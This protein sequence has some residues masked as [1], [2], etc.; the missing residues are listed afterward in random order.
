MTLDVERILAQ[1]SSGLPRYTSYPPANHFVPG[2]GAALTDA[3]AQAARE[4]DA[5]SL[6]IHIPFCDRMCWFCGCHTKQ[7][8]RHDPVVT[9]IGDLVEEIALWGRKLG[10]RPKVSKLHLGGGSPSLLQAQDLAAIRQALHAAFD[11]SSE[12]E[13]SIEIDPSDVKSAS[14]D[15]LM[16]VGMTRAS[17]GVQD[18][19]PV[20]QA[21][22]N[23]PQSFELTRDI[24]EAL[25]AAGIGS[26]NIDALYGLP[27]Q[28]QDRFVRTV[29]QVIALQ[30]DR[31]AL[32]GYAHVPWMKTHQRMIKDE[33]LPNGLQRFH[34]AEV[35]SAMIA[36]A[37]YQVIGIDHFAKPDDSLAIAARNGKLHRNFQGYTDDDA[38]V[39]LGFGASAIGCFDGGFVQ[40]EVATGRY[41]DM[42]RKGSIPLA[43]GLALNEEDRL[44]GRVIELLMCD[45]GFAYGQ[46]EREFGPAVAAP[47]ISLARKVAALDKDGLCRSSTTGFEM[48]PDARPFV[49]IVAARFDQWLQRTEGK[50]SKVV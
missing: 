42:V 25:R 20:V 7:V 41:Q 12:P 4:A 3:L 34:D 43:R 37:G 45:F 50:Y 16:A 13:V 1:Q 17:I 9:Y 38:A 46:L 15:N 11:F 19:D 21:A 6:Y 18:F 23:R 26:I 39:R 14:I 30:P 36:R 8:Q 29:E 49:R 31:I 27:L 48:T 40:N 32:F 28:T 33:D 24:V 5:V 44:Y 10:Q 2:G 35:G 47:A 22:I